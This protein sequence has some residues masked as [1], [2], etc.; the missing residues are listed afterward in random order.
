MGNT[1]GYFSLAALEGMVTNP[2]TGDLC[3]DWCLETNCD[4]FTAIDKDM[5][6][7]FGECHFSKFDSETYS[8]ETFSAG[9]GRD[10]QN[11]QYKVK[12]F[13]KN[14]QGLIFRCSFINL[15]NKV[16]IAL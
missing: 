10:S 4:S 6:G 11:S 14:V 3:L 5:N 15:Q 8:V 16:G 1:I 7:L 9:T 13:S 12:I 2:Q